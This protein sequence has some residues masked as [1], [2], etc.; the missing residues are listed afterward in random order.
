MVHGMLIVMPFCP[1]CGTKAESGQSFCENCGSSLQEPAQQTVSPYSPQASPPPIPP[2][3]PPVFS[4]S[5]PPPQEHVSP[6]TPAGFKKYKLP[7]IAIACV[8]VIIIVFLAIPKVSSQTAASQTPV[9][10]PY[11]PATPYS[12]PVPSP[13]A[14]QQ[15]YSTRPSTPGTTSPT[16]S[17]QISGGAFSTTEY[18][19]SSRAQFRANRTAGPAPFT[20]SFY[21]LTLGGPVKWVWDFGDTS[22]SSERNPVH[23]YK[24]PGKYLVTMNTVISGTMYSNSMNITVTGS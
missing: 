19:S 9:P 5:A 15:V 7:I 17:G 6:Q 18:G 24:T 13:S 22:G 8:L 2:P 11:Q 3:S 12:T 21:D 16:V 14:A 10:T 1:M 4:P 23:T 20:V